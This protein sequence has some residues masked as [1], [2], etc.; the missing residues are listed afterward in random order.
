MTTSAERHLATV[1][2]S[3]ALGLVG[4]AVSAA[5]TFVLVMVVTTSVAP[6][7]AGQ[8]FAVTSFFLLLMA[9]AGLGTDTGLGRFLL[10]YEALGRHRD[11]RTIHRAALVPSV[12]AAVVL[13]LP[14]LVAPGPVS[15][16]LDLDGDAG[17]LVATA[18]A[19]PLV[20]A[21]YV[22][23]AGTRAFGRMRTTVVADS[24]LRPLAQLGA[25][26]VIGAAGG[27]LASMTGAW[28]GAY[29]VAAVVGAVSFHR[30]LTR[31]L[32]RPEALRGESAASA[33]SVWREFWAYTWARG[34]A[35]LAQMAL[36]R[37]D[38]I[39]IA[40]MLGATEAAVYTAATRF[41]AL[42]KFPA[43]AIQQVLQP[44]FTAL[45]AEEDHDATREVYQVSTAWS[46]AVSWPV[47]VVV[48]CAPQT[49]LSLFGSSYQEAGVSVV[50]WMVVGMMATLLAGPAD[51]LL[52][53]AGRSTVSL[54]ISLLALTIDVVGCLVLIP[55]VG[56]TG[57][58]ASWGF[59]AATR[60]LLCFW[61]VRRSA[62]VRSISVGSAWVAGANVLAFA[63]PV[64]LVQ[65]ALGQ[66]EVWQ[67]ALVV[68]LCLP[69]YA[70]VLTLG[71]HSLHASTL[72]A[73][74][75]GRRRR[76]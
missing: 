56:I 62:G 2:R 33:R 61:F 44:R 55:T 15:R 68:V 4:S 39:L 8:F 30:M 26:V 57:A 21:G 70:A 1:A 31:R 22:G 54:A 41:V 38:I 50:W 27:G 46:M 64:V 9:L 37:L 10:R 72:R 52:L 23:L 5:S 19:L 14:C 43:Q 71:R 28:L 76:G 60:S 35:K 7:R 73:A 59:A 67:L 6:E 34:V 29:V 13:A 48:G 11:L 75:S 32:A 25:L 17:V 66:L 47:Y 49:Y 42:G 65:A 36:Q 24:I 53:M 16:V 40:A 45:V 74:L 20:V 51:T 12:G 58:A 3:G 69:I 18:A 63:V